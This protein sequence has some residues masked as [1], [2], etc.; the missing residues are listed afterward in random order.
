M[1]LHRVLFI[2]VSS[3]SGIGEYMRSMIIAKALLT[4]WPALEVHFLLNEQVSYINDCPYHVHLCKDSPTKDTASVNQA[5]EQ[6][7]PNLVIFDASGRAKQFKKAK[8]LGAKVAFISQHNKKRA[9]GL[10]LNRL[11]HIDNH[12]VA[13]PD[14]CM[15][16]LN[17][18]QRIKLFLCKKSSPKNIGPVFEMASEEYQEKILQNYDLVAKQYFIFNAGS[19]GHLVGDKLAADIYFQAAKALYQKTKQTC[20]VVF[21]N[22]YPKSLPSDDGVLCIKNIDNKDFVA[23]LA[24]AQIC[25]I[26]AGDTLLQCLALGNTC[27][28]APVSPD[29]PERLKRCQSHEQVFPAQPTVDDVLSQTMQSLEIINNTSNVKRKTGSVHANAL[30]IVVDDIAMLFD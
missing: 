8:N 29:Q 9:R 30:D 21:G 18:M 10:K 15:K 5:L 2:P 24:G 11:P 17:L 26:S 12:W 13:Q 1:E 25:I 23:L 19:G 3:P 27:V 28:A 4:R 7:N 22:N 6:V 14:F 16:P 20:L